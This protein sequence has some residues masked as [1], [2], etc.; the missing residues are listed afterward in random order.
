MISRGLQTKTVNKCELIL[1]IERAPVLYSQAVDLQPRCN[2]KTVCLWL[3]LLHDSRERTTA[4]VMQCI[5]QTTC[6][7]LT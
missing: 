4:T 5:D 7:D 1:A 2:M 3:T 6:F